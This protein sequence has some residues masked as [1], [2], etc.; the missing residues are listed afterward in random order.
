MSHNSINIIQKIHIRVD[1]IML[2]NVFTV[3]SYQYASLHLSV[4]NYA[5][6]SVLTISTVRIHLP[7]KNA[8]SHRCLLYDKWREI[9]GKNYSRGGRKSGIIIQRKEREKLRIKKMFALISY[10]Y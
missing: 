3:L 4:Q 2:Q 8:T 1:G 7:E 6:K 10:L 9:L 5:T